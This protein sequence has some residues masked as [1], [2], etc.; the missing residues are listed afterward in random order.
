MDV[1]QIVTIF[2]AG[3]MTG[4][5][6]GYLYLTDYIKKYYKVDIEKMFKDREAEKNK[7]MSKSKSV[8]VQFLIVLGTVI[9]FI[10]AAY[11]LVLFIVGLF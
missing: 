1:G 5:L 11:M 2:L 3:V 8:G 6:I 10:F 4:M 7:E 9:M